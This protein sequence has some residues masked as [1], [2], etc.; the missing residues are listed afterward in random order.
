MA[1]SEQ[2][3]VAWAHVVEATTVY[4]GVDT[5][6]WSP[7]PGGTDAVWCGRL[8]PE[9]APHAAIDA[10]RAAR[11]SLQ[12]VGP[13]YDHE[14]FARQIVPR[15]GA[16]VRWLG[17]LSQREVHRV[18]ARARV[19]VVT[20]AWEEPYGLVAAEAMSCGTPVAAFARGAMREV[21]DEHTGRLAPAG[22]VAALA[23]AIGAAARLPRHRVRS[24]AVER[25]G[26]TR[27]V[28]EY[29][30]VYLAMTAQGAAA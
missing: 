22:D 12:L 8:V 18:V 15:L 28:D 13:V 26:L 21:V 10:A 19:A 3:K 27:M 1:V 23:R 9:K 29:E 11:L 6:L 17:H 2:M 5:D 16:D 14:Y 30:S 7:G 20:P 25:W 4:N 24:R